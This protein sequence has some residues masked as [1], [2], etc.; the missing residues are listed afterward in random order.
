MAPATK[1][2]SLL[3]GELYGNRVFVELTVKPSP[4]ASCNNNPDYTYVFDPTT[5]VGKVTLAL[6]MEAHASQ[7][8][9]YISGMDTCTFYPGVESLGQVWV[10]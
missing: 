2:K 4:T 9:V 5:P 7:A 6:L 8:N 10:K 1:I 3:A